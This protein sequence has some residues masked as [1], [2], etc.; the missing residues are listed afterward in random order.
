M[1]LNRVC[2]R[3][4]FR[5]HRP[6]HML[7]KARAFATSFHLEIEDVKVCPESHKPS[8]CCVLGLLFLA[9]IWSCLFTDCFDHEANVLK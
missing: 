3:Q 9:L 1:T 7:E 6:R 8:F 4:G 2:G 5:L